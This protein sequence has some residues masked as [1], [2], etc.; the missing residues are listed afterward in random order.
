MYSTSNISTTTGS[1]PTVPFCRRVFPEEAIAAKGEIPS[2]P[3]LQQI[4]GAKHGDPVIQK[5]GDVVLRENRVVVWPNVFQTRLNGFK[6]DDKEKEGRLRLVTLRLIDPNRRIMSTAMVPCLRGDWWA[7][8]VGRTCPALYRLPTEIF[9]H[10]IQMIDDGS[11][12]ISVDQAES[13][14]EDFKQQRELFRQKHTA[15]KERYDDWDI[16]GEPGVGDGDDGE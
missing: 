1:C 9:Q 5:L 11:Y 3:F 2:P 12:P 7:D 8:A 10:H 4:Y 6:L 16:Y 13:D 14:R 15:A